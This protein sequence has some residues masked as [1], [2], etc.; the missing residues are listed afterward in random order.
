MEKIRFCDVLAIFV[1][2]MNLAQKVSSLQCYTCDAY[3]D[4][5][6]PCTV[7][8]RYS[9]QVLNCSNKCYSEVTRVGSCIINFKRG[10]TLS[11]DCEEE[12]ECAEF[13]QVGTCRRCCTENNCNN[14]DAMAVVP[15]TET[16][17]GSTAITISLASAWSIYS[18]GLLSQYVF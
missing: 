11:N 14:E 5:G 1:S 6:T 13:I 10:C 15:I 12:S 2:V 18:F 7:N 4:F 17:P 3:L 16:E 8:D 9:P